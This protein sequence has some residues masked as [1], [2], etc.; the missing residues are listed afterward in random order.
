MANATFDTL[1]DVAADLSGEILEV[2]VLDPDLD[3]NQVLQ[4]DQEW[5]VKARWKVSGLC[6]PGLGGDWKLLVKL[7]S[8]GEGFEGIAQTKIVPVSD[9]APD[10]T[11]TYETTITMPKPVD[12]PGFIAGTYKMVLVITHS[13]T[14]GGVTKR[15]RMAGFNDGPLL[16]FVDPEV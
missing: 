11:R 9:V 12:L 3:P 13:N 16:E 5:S 14:G 1:T 8:I 4:D 10:A 6:A 15:T 2:T 7:E